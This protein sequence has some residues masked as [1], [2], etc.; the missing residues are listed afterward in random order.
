MKLIN[1]ILTNAAPHF[2]EGGR[3]QRWY[4]L[5]E[6][7]DSFILGSDQKTCIAPHVRDGMDLKRIMT[8]V[9]IS[10]LP[11]V[12]MA[13]W[14]TG[15]QANSTLQSL[16]ISLPSGWRGSIMSIWG[17][18]PAS[19]WSNILLGSLYFLPVYLVSLTIGGIW[20]CVFNI[21]RGHE[22][23]EA[24]L[25]TSLLFALILPPTIPL[26]QVAIGIS[27]G[28][29]FAKEMF[30]G[31]GRNF[32]NPALAARAFIFFAYPAQ[33]S[34]DQIW[35]AVDGFSRATPLSVLS[36]AQPGQ[37]I[38]SL[39][40]T[41]QQAFIGTIP[42]SLGE[43][44][45]LACLIGAIILLITGIASW[46][47]ISAILLGGLGCALAF[48]LTNS[49][50]N[51][52]FNVPPHWHLVLGGFAFGMVFMATDPV[53]APHTAAGQ[54]IYGILIGVLAIIIRVANPAF[55]EGVMLAILLGNV[56]APLFDYFVVQSN[57][58]RRILRHGK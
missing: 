39:S 27:F 57:I 16:G 50:T 33:M 4:P 58:K 29:I 46:R 55:P 25:V 9:V 13:L 54:W 22:M 37:A 18:N 8:M 1:K 17:C 52:M 51:P 30:G 6:A 48:W 44:S 40:I 11:C 19:A 34:G 26:W 23:S 21:I 36:A 53:S 56:F 38:H 32:I 10:L 45:T 2:K 31:V 28:V 12:F 49:P 41:W 24:F 7:T 42:G 35:T 15:Y 3:L 43:T 47:I 14:N 20:E 5:F